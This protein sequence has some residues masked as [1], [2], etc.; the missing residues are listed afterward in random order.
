MNE[1]KHDLSQFPIHDA[2]IV[3][4]NGDPVDIPLR[5]AHF[6]Y[7]I[8]AMHELKPPIP[9]QHTGSIGE[10][11]V[12]MK[13][14]RYALR[15]GV[16]EA[17][18]VS[19]ADMKR[20]ASFIDAH[21]KEWIAS[22]LYGAR[23]ATAREIQTGLTREALREAYDRVATWYELP[24]AI[25]DMLGAEID[26]VR[27]RYGNDLVLDAMGTAQ[28]TQM[29]LSSA[30]AHHVSLFELKESMRKASASIAA[31]FSAA[32]AVMAAIT[33][34]A[35]ADAV[36]AASDVMPRNRQ[37]RRTRKHTKPMR[38]G[39]QAWKRRKRRD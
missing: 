5:N 27:Q 3:E 6:T 22:A 30:I 19:D 16:D 32:S 8:P 21:T 18:P 35:Y 15:I 28:R 37:E 17:A 24:P 31:A 9:S 38:E 7:T 34:S 29:P 10:A 13:I 23:P 2:R 12:T 14:E 1:D 20:I 39:D 4:I 36:D 26:R 25:V 33:K 11:T